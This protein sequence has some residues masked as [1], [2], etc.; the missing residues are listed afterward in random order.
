MKVLFEV[1]HGELTQ[2]RGLNQSKRLKQRAVHGDPFKKVTELIAQKS[3]ELGVSVVS[4]YAQIYK[5][6]APGK[7]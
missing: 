2:T 5:H 4:L 1:C 7:N 6:S 3:F